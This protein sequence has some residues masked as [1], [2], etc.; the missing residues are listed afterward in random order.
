MNML[1]MFFQ[2][3]EE[4]LEESKF[5]CEDDYRKQLMDKNPDR[6]QAIEHSRQEEAHSSLGA[7]LGRIISQFKEDCLVAPTRPAQRNNPYAAD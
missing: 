2:S 1:E 3:R 6:Y 7:R 4:A 5:H